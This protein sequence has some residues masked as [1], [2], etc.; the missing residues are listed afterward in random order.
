MNKK[1]A[2]VTGASRGFGAAVAEELAADG[3]HVIALAQTVGGLEDLDD[4]ISARGGEVT[5]VPLDITEDK[6]LQQMCLSVNERWGRI[7]LLVHSAIYV[8]P[9]SPA[10]H[11]PES[12]WDKML[13]TDIRATQ[14][15]ITMIEPLLNMAEN[16]TAVLPTED[17]AGKKFQA[18]YGAA[19]AAQQAIWD[20]WAAETINIGPK[21]LT[22]APNPMP[23]A[24]RGR[25]YPGE[26]RDEL[27]LPNDEARRMIDLV[28]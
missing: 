24:L 22:F 16:G 8:A 23:T 13:A 1:I 11:V 15:I 18:A 12:D 19:K 4:R 14:R 20:S 21:V 25:F 17:V 7:D 5:L 6:S 9:L 10:G 28:L 26:D 2:L 27:A 3:W